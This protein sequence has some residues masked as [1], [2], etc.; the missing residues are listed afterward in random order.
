MTSLIPFIPLL[1]FAG[2][3]VNATMGK[4]IPKSV[5]GGLASLVMVLSF[6]ISAYL[7]WNLAQLEPSTSTSMNAANRFRY[8]K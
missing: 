4:R 3:V 2:F 7:V 8:E 1:P 6:L 5:S